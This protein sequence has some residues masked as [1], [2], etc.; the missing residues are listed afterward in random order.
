VSSNSLACILAAALAVTFPAFANA[1][2]VA[3]M[4]QVE[5]R[6]LDGGQ[7]ATADRHWLA[8]VEISM[9]VGWKTYWRHPGD[10]GIPPSFDFSGSTNVANVEV[11]WP[12]PSLGHDGFGW[13]VGYEREVVF[14]V[15]VTP[16]DPSKPVV[17][18]LALGYAVCAEICIP[19]N[20]E[21]GRT[22]DETGPDR[23]PIEL[24][25]AAVPVPVDDGD[26]RGGVL[27]IT[28]T[29]TADGMA[30]DVTARFPAG[31]DEPALLVEGP[32]DWYPPIP[33]LVAHGDDG[34]ATFR[35]PPGTLPD[36]DGAAGTELL[37]TGLSPT[38]SFEQKLTLP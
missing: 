3:K 23:L 6:L 25:L 16:E 27:R 34:T 24:Y 17:L 4:P 22:L 9:E 32:A 28:R 19:L 30:L 35:L 12:A 14:P 5:M 11:K 2:P 20:D 29:E 37:V 10:A 15:V 31:T 21:A 7:L 1:G 36:N 26:P 18:S 38:F 33:D 8:G 13:V